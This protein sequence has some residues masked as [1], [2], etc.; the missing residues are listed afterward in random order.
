MGEGGASRSGRGNVG[1]VPGLV[2][3]GHLG[4]AHGDHNRPPARLLREPRTKP[5]GVSSAVTN[6]HWTSRRGTVA[7]DSCLSNDSIADGA[8]LYF[9]VLFLSD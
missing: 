2:L 3:L 6:V 1:P 8:I 7:D 4:R 5:A 9:C